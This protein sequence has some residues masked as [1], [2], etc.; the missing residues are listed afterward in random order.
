M[1]AGSEDPSA[2]PI[3][4]PGGAPGLART[5]RAAPAASP[6]GTPPVA[7]RPR[8]ARPRRAVRRDGVSISE[9][10]KDAQRSMSTSSLPGENAP[11]ISMCCHYGSRRQN[12]SIAKNSHRRRVWRARNPLSTQPR[13]EPVPQGT[14]CASRSTMA[15]RRP[16]ASPRQAAAVGKTGAGPSPLNRHSQS[17]RCSLRF[18]SL[19]RA[20][21]PP[22]ATS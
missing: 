6:P 1:R 12:A 3:H 5:D 15:M 9:R 20:V 13:S 14:W 18:C 21:H 2:F 10:A 8:P 4:A 16:T 22:L 17:P 11:T 19:T 7:S